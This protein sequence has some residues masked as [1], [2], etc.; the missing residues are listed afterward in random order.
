MAKTTSATTETEA[1]AEAPVGVI[2]AFG[3][4][5]GLFAAQL[6]NFLIVLV[7]LW[8]FVY[9][10][11]IAML[12]AREKKIA[13]SMKDVDDIAARVK[14]SDADR[15]EQILATRKETQEMIDI[16]IR[17]TEARKNEMLDAA[18]HEVERVIEQGKAKLAAE[19]E[20]SLLAMRKDIV[21]IAVRA[22]A[23]IVT[24]GMNEKKSQSLAEEVVRKLT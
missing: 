13:Q 3:I 4:S 23:K 8:K 12:D 24:E 18:K 22:A 19:R 2:G 10:P 6:V 17:D 9:T 21:D 20:A 1:H 14:A 15:Q 11:M 16:A 5:G 7:V